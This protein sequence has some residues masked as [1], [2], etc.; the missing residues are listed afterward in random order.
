MKNNSRN[1]PKTGR[2]LILLGLVILAW[3]CSPGTGKQNDSGHDDPLQET[4]APP[5]TDLHT[6][7]V[8]GDL[9]AIE[10]H[11]R[12]G[13]DLN[14]RE[15]LM[16]STPLI[17]AVIFGKTESAR[18]LILGGA[19][20]NAQNNEGTTALHSAAFFCRKDLV[21]LLLEHGADKTLRNAYG[22]TPLESISGPFEEVLPIYEQ[23]NRDLGALGF[24]VDCDKIRELRP[25]IAHLLK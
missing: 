11:I 17:S 8:L 24:R 6:A 9:K 2:I 14:V 5:E 22:S 4:I 10:Q 20:L 7:T 25:Q 23:F 1:E 18:A 21:E 3:A 13:S 12:A 16:S 19:D 15:P